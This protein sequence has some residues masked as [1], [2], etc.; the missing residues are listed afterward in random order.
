MP[1][2]VFPSQREHGRIKLSIDII[3]HLNKNDDNLLSGVMGERTKFWCDHRGED[4]DDEVGEDGEDADWI[5]NW[6]W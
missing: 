2:L 5:T 1:P 3:R 4:D 6:R